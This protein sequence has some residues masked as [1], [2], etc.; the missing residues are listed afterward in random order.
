MSVTPPNTR[1]EGRVWPLAHTMVFSP[2]YYAIPDD[3]RVTYVDSVSDI[4]A[5]I[6]TSDTVPS[7]LFMNDPIQ[8]KDILYD[9]ELPGGDDDKDFGLTYAEFLPIPVTWFIPCVRTIVGDP[10][11]QFP[12]DA[13][14]WAAVLK[15]HYTSRRDTD[16]VL[17]L[18]YVLFSGHLQRS[19]VCIAGN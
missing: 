19:A 2:L 12:S 5:R 9:Y 11:R 3:A 14:I 7:F 16:E 13:T 15:V 18:F 17:D 6:V 10:L 4:R 8:I 1:L